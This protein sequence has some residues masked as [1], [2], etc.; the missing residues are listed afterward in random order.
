MQSII[1]VIYWSSNLSFSFPYPWSIWPRLLRCLMHPTTS[2]LF[3]NISSFRYFAISSFGSQFDFFT[4]LVIPFRM[5]SHNTILREA[6]NSCSVSLS[7]VAF[8]LLRLF[9][10]HL[11]YVW[12]FV[13]KWH[14]RLPF[15]SSTSNGTYIFPSGTTHGVPI[16]AFSSTVTSW[17]FPLIWTT[18]MGDLYLHS[19]SIWH[20]WCSIASTCTRI[21][22]EKY[23]A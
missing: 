14:K 17:G 23:R 1:V 19:L 22:L 6:C 15:H 10:C 13:I 9:L 8:P 12:S 20:L 11:F 7:L 5:A 21:I 2:T 3:E 18:F 16:T 4:R